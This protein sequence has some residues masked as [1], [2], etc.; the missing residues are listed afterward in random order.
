M[1]SNRTI[2]PRSCTKTTKG[3]RGEAQWLMVLAEAA[4]K[5]A[6]GA[7]GALLNDYLPLLAEAA[8]Q[9]ASPNRDRIDAVRQQ[10]RRAAE[11]GVPVGRGVELYLSA[12]RRMWGELPVAVREPHRVAAHSAAQAVLRVVEEAVAAFAEGHAEAGREMVR[13]EETQRRE[14]VEDLLRGDARLSDLVGRAEPFGLDLTSDHQVALA[15]P[16]GRL[17][18]ID[19]AVTALE[20]VVLDRLGDRDVLVATKDGLVVVNALVEGSG[21]PRRSDGPGPTGGLGKIM[22]SELR[23]LRRGP[24]WQVVVGRAHRGAYGIARSYEEAR[25]GLTIAARIKLHHPVVETSDLLIYRLLARD[26]PALVDL[27]HSV[28]DPLQGARG[29]ARPLLD[30]LAAYFECGCV[31]TLTATRMHL[32]V[33]AVIYRFDRVRILTGFDP[34]EP[35]HRFTLQTATLGAMLLGWP[36]QH[37]PRSNGSTLASASR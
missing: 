16:E 33:R 2:N 13:R 12:A 31:A 28:L 3:G 14:L 23:R 10:G 34:L 20:R 15:R 35:A 6:G 19:V 32:S 9:G 21:A 8:Q 29:G 7:P 24:P 5:D 25:E 1:T 37:P 11:R 30:T 22:H 18:S 27:V 4:S 36:D 26:Q 17:P